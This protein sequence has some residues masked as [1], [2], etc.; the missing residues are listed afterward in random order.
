MNL[1][2]LRGW[3]LEVSFLHKSPPAPLKSYPFSEELDQKSIQPLA[4]RDDRKPVNAGLILKRKKWL[5]L[6]FVSG[7][8]PQE[9]LGFEFTLSE[10]HGAS[11]CRV[12]IGS[13]V[14]W[15]YLWSTWQGKTQNLCGWTQ[16]ILTDKPQPRW[17]QC[18]KVPIEG[19]INSE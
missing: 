18:P 1:W 2:D 11:V 8:C 19:K 5:P 4:Q 14:G 12:R 15:S 17:D 9:R 13:T 10:W 3:R 7:G 16:R 6:G